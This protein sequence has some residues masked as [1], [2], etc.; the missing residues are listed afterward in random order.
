MK[1]ASLE[2]TTWGNII[3]GCDFRHGE[4]SYRKMD[5]LNGHSR[6]H[7]VNSWTVSGDDFGHMSGMDFGDSDEVQAPAWSHKD[8]IK[9]TRIS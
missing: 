6:V 2:T 4:R 7:G 5:H 8:R 1:R 3:V 9:Q